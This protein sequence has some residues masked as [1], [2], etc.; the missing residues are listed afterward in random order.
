MRKTALILLVAVLSASGQTR[1]VGLELGY[2]SVNFGKLNSMLNDS[3]D[4]LLNRNYSVEKTD[5]GSAIF[6]GVYYDH[7]IQRQFTIGPKIEYIR[8][9]SSELD[10]SM[11]GSSFN[12]VRSAWLVPLMVGGKFFLP[13][14][15]PLWSVWG[16]A[17]I[18]QAFGGT[19]EEVKLDNYLGSDADYE[20]PASGSRWIFEIAAAAEYGLSS[21]FSIAVE[22]AYRFCDVDEMTVTEDV[23]EAG[24]EDGFD[25]ED[26]GRDV[27]FDYSGVKLGL[28]IKFRL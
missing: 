28:G 27:H 2:T 20:V 1:G 7:P 15:S 10:A 17:Y 23:N 11:S 14:S 9:F 25:L 16:G 5:F 21:A 13:I 26:H 3:K 24:L 6:L 22:L 18:G 4:N 12:S 8:L 19:L